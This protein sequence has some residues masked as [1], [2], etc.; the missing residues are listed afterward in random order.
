M[1]ALIGYSS[2]GIVCAIQCLYRNLLQV[3]YSFSP[4]C[5]SNLTPNLK[6]MAGIFHRTPKAERWMQKILLLNPKYCRGVLLL[7]SANK[8]LNAK[9]YILFLAFSNSQLLQNISVIKVL[10]HGTS[11]E[12]QETNIWSVSDNQYANH[13]AK[14]RH[15]QHTVEPLY[16]GHPGDREV[17][18]MG[19]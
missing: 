16:N 11:C 8:L 2:W 13:H 15:R 18:L 19:R 7:I 12:V 3:R 4:K 1:C 5:D 6:E 10:V 14:L 9:Y 17:A